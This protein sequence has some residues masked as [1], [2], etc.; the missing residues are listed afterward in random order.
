[1]TNPNTILIRIEF[2]WVW[3]VLADVLAVL[4][5]LAVL[6]ALTASIALIVLTAEA[7]VAAVIAVEDTIAEAVIAVV[8]EAIVAAVDRFQSLTKTPIAYEEVKGPYNI[9][10][11]LHYNN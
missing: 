2:S 11:A 4:V 10:G 9:V 5:A 3:V 1:M 8:A 7:I 6:T